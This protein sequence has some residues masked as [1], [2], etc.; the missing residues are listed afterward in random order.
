MTD[1]TDAFSDTDEDEEENT[2]PG[3]IETPEAV[4]SKTTQIINTLMSAGQWGSVSSSIIVPTGNN[5]W[6]LRIHFNNGTTRRV[7]VGGNG[8]VTNDTT[9][10]TNL[11]Q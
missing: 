1:N 8:G 9:G 7:R 10:P 11:L 6:E 2:S 3:G 5:M 4:T